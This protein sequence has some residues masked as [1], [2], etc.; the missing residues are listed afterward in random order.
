MTMLL[1]L[2]PSLFIDAREAAASGVRGP[3]EWFS[4]SVLSAVSAE[5][6]MWLKLQ[7]A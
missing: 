7:G 1:D 4:K 2:D 3:V 6:R 5:T